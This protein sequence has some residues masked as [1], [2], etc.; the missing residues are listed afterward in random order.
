MDKLNLIY[1]HLDTSTRV[2]VSWPNGVEL[3]DTEG[4]IALRNSRNIPGNRLGEKI[5]LLDII[6]KG[7]TQGYLNILSVDEIPNDAYYVFPIEII[8]QMRYWSHYL[9]KPLCIPEQVEKDVIAGK[10]KILFI[11]PFEGSSIFQNDQIAFLRQQKLKYNNNIIYS[12]SNMLVEEALSSENI[13]GIYHNPWVNTNNNIIIKQYIN[14]LKES[15]INKHIR[16]NKFMCFNRI[17]RPARAYMVNRMLELDLVKNN[18][19][20]FQMNERIIKAGYAWDYYANTHGYKNLDSLKK[21]IPLVYDYEDISKVNPTDIHIQ[22]HKD[23]YFNIVNET[24]FYNQPPSMFFSEKT[25]KPILCM[26]PFVLA[27]VTNS[28]KFLKQIGFKTFNNFID[29]SYD[30]II[31]DNERLDKIIEVV[32]FIN[33]KTSKELS[34]MLYQMYPILLHNYNHHMVVAEQEIGIKKLASRILNE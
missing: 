15:I 28:L 32:Q 14:E 2:T 20:T 1:A 6:F 11:V 25:F 10:A 26:Q 7:K 27:G 12:D 13:K 8:D 24:I 16:P 17:P 22:P 29:E 5:S 23:S 34:E 18:I 30:D 33:N 19:V 3:N 9:N 21:S 31:D 4:F